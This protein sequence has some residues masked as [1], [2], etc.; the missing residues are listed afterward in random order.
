MLTNPMNLYRINL[1]LL[2]VFD[3]LLKEKHVSNAAKR[4]HI[5]QSAMSKLL[6]QCREIFNDPLLIKVSGSMVPTHRA[7]EIHD[8]VREILQRIETVLTKKTEFNPDTFQ[9]HI[10]I[11][12]PDTIS[13]FMLPILSKTI[14]PIAPNIQLEAKSVNAKSL[15]NQLRNDD[16]QM[17]I[18][19]GYNLPSELNSAPLYNDKPVC[20]GRLKHPIF[21]GKA[22]TIDKFLKY[23]HV[24]IRYSES[25]M[26]RGD[27]ILQ[28]Y[29]F[30]PRKIALTSANVISILPI[31][32]ST[33]FLVSVGE[34]FAKQFYKPFELDYRPLPIETLTIPIT[35]VWLPT[36]NNLAWHAW[37]R[38]LILNIK[39]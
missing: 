12:M 15:V 28:Q 20:L 31:I 11:G 37:L 5:T 7:L 3:T 38:E 24:V 26:A 23:K 9:K 22:I 17:A 34:L 32:S 27:Q 4:L 13:S 10:H 6:A 1:N 16:I 29:G 8:E 25:R 39:L 21:S 35:L 36:Y 2:V 30:D 18:T 19:Y 14:Q 33:D